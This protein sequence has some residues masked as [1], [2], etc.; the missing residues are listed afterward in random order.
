MAAAAD[1]IERIE[2]ERFKFESALMLIET[3]YGDAA[4]LAAAALVRK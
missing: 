2:K 4:K 3:G 1:E